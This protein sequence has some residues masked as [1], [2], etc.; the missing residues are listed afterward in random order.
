MDDSL[1]WQHE[2]EEQQ[3]RYYFLLCTATYDQWMYASSY[4]DPNPET[5]IE[6]E[7]NHSE[8]S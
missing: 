1:L 2:Q 7:R 6:T 4:K 8:L 5:E 3:Q